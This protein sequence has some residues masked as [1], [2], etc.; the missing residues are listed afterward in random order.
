MGPHCYRIGFA[1]HYLNDQAW[2]YTGHSCDMRVNGAIELRQTVL[3]P[4]CWHTLKDLPEKCSLRDICLGYQ[5]CTIDPDPGS[6]KPG[7][8]DKVTSHNTAL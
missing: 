1:D 6:A 4:I 7:V 8:V 5:P 3:V 2:L